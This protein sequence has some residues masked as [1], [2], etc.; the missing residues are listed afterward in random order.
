MRVVE[1][2]ELHFIELLQTDDVGIAAF[3]AAREADKYPGENGQ[4]DFVQNAAYVMIEIGAK[5]AVP[6]V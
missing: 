2:F 3:F 6:E 1:N 4:A 5:T